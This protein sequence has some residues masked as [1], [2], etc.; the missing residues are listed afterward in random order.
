MREFVCVR[1][2]VRACVRVCEG[3]CV[4]MLCV[5][6]LCVSVFVYVCMCC[7]FVHACSM[8]VSCVRG[9]MSAFLSD[10]ILIIIIKINIKAFIYHNESRLPC[11]KVLPCILI[12]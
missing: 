3:V 7:M 9:C 8:C 2:C 5:H 4:C 6:F 10:K 11:L 12:D 1:A